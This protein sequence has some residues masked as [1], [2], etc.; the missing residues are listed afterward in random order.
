MIPSYLPRAGAWGISM[1]GRVSVRLLAGVILLL[2]FS[3]VSFQADGGSPTPIGSAVSVGARFTPLGD[4]PGGSFDCTAFGVSADGRVA[5]GQ[6]TSDL[7]HEA[8]VWMSGSGPL[9]LGPAPGN[10]FGAIA[11]AASDDGVFVAGFLQRTAT[12]FAGFR[13]SA[14]TGLQFIDDIPGGPASNSAVDLSSDGSVVVGLGNSLN[15]IEAYRWTAAAGAVGLGDLPGLP[16]TSHSN[17]VSGDGTIVVG[18]G[19]VL[20]GDAGGEGWRWTAESGMVGLGDL[21][22]GVFESSAETISRNGKY[23][24]G[25]GTGAEGRMA[26]RWSA[27]EG[28]RPLGEIPGGVFMSWGRAVSDDGDVAGVSSGPGGNEAILWTP[29]LGMVPVAP[30][31]RLFGATGLDGWRLNSVEGIAADGRT[32]VGSGTD[33]DGHNQA[34]VATLPASLVCQP[35]ECNPCVDADGDGWGD[36][37][38]PTNIC[39]D[40]NCPAVPNSD[41]QDL[42]GD[43]RGDACDVCPRDPFDDADHDGV[44]A[45]ADD[46]PF[47]FNP[48][49]SDLDG[50]GLGDACDNCPAVGN[51]AQTDGDFDGVGDACDVCPGLASPDQA[52]QDGDG[53]GDACDNCPD[54]AN[55]DQA[56]SNRDGSGDACQPVV[57]IGAIVSTGLTLETNVTA[58]DPQGEALSGSVDFFTPAAD[59]TI[60]DLFGTLDCNSGYLPQGVHGQGIGYSN[61]ASGAPYLF[62]LDTYL[63]CDDGVADYV[64]A[65]GP[66]HAPTGIFDS[67]LPLDGLTPPFAV[68]VR[69]A[70]VPFGGADWTVMAIEPESIHASVQEN[71]KV[72]GI[73]FLSALPHEVELDLLNDPGHSYE[74]RITLTDGNTVPVSARK[75]FLYRSE[76]RMVFLTGGAPQAAIAAQT[77]VECTGPGGAGV[78]LDGSAS[79][80]PDS[81]PGT[82]DDIASLDW[83]EAYGL[84]TQRPLGSGETLSVTLPLG[85]HAI[86]LKVT[87]KVGQSSTDTSSV[88][89]VDTMPPTL[90]LQTDPMTLWPPNHEMV[91]VHVSWVALDLCDVSASVHLVS[92][93]SSELDD[94][95]GNN[96]GA[97]TN[98]IQ[99]AEFGTPDMALLLRSERDGKGSGRVYT[100]TYRAQDRSGNTTPALATV[101]VAHDQGQ[102]PEPLLMQVEPTVRGSADLRIYWPSVEGATGYDVITGDLASWHVNNGVLS[103]GPAHV[104]AQSTMM[105]SI[106]EPAAS[107]TPAEGQC[108]FYLIQQRTEAG[109]AG[110]GT[111]TGPWPRVPETCGGDCPGTTI[112]TTAGGSGGNQT[113]RR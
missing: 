35:G 46:C 4:L 76:S 50:D 67:L 55:R 61:A 100:L 65:I 1:T 19:N 90:T 98:D 31:L 45:D 37:G 84:A 93:T 23:V 92:V 87:D 63:G 89:I 27:D 25:Y 16:F 38:V 79:T 103:L 110:Y 3:A 30:L 105:T 33:P 20:F 99:G 5:V 95:P 77:S 12:S 71:R 28:M 24:A 68:C 56:D 36:P 18:H 101:T 9:S 21:P 6:G 97:T 59:V 112:A 8:V 54:T 85:A 48:G 52:D 81:T 17:G 39:P 32:L 57:S 29:D 60:P 15:G 2:V 111:E 74:L 102:G 80:D 82:N 96:D 53:V 47:V 86:T 69:P 108:F 113:T 88:S 109:A 78:L 91:P 62:D 73:S 64:I 66:C 13:W 43:G 104:L 40:D 7:G 10:S 70:G 41:Q 42:D 106:T 72:F 94:A 22:G 83:F 34:W 51:P 49:Q 75:T 44:C 14:A 107:A 58:R 26:F 11:E